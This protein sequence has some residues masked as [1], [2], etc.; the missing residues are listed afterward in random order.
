MYV[1]A[2]NRPSARRDLIEQ[3][4][5]DPDLGVFATQA[6]SARSWYQVDNSAIETI[7]AEMIDDVNFGRASVRAALQAAENKVSV[8]MS[9]SRRNSF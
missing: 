8:L 7:F 4:E 2:S 3:Q 9:R 5:T 1:N 6:L